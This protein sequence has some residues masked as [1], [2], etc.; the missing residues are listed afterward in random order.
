MDESMHKERTKHAGPF[1]GFATARQEPAE[2][3][4]RSLGPEELR[5]EERK[6]E[7]QERNKDGSY[8]QKD[9]GPLQ[10]NL[11][12]LATVL[13]GEGEAKAT[14]AA[15]AKSNTWKSEV[16]IPWRYLYGCVHVTFRPAKLVAL[17]KYKNC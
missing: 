10:G 12:Q 1:F 17:A 3:A 4:P 13:M 16:G 9:L 15:G 8:M 5:Q 14:F 11:Q 7:R 2:P 6:M